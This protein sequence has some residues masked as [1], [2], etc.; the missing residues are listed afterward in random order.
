M[1][2]PARGGSKGIPRKN[3]REL[4]GKPLICR[5]IDVARSIVP[6]NDICVTTDD[7]EI[8]R[9]VEEYGLSV[10]FVRPAYLATDTMGTYDVLIHALNF[11]HFTNFIML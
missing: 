4:D 9:T 1:I 3:I 10:P 6:D 8:I 2:I 11:Y 5:S 7:V